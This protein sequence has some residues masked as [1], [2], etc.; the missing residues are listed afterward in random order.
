MKKLLAMLLAALLILSLAACTEKA[1][2][3]T[4]ISESNAP[5][6]AA[7]APEATA[8]V[9]PAASDPAISGSITFTH[10]R[11]DLEPEI[12]AIIDD[13]MKE[14]PDVTVDIE[15]V[16]DYVNNIGVRLS[17]NEVPD[18]FFVDE[19]II[20]HDDWGKYL[21][22][23]DGSEVA[24]RDLLGNCWLRDGHTYAISSGCSYLTFFY[25]KTLWTEAGIEGTP[26][27]WAEFESAMDKLSKLDGII[28]L[29]TQYKTGWAISEWLDVYA[30]AYQ[31]ATGGVP[32][33]LMNNW[34]NK[35]DPFSDK[36]SIQILDNFKGLIEKGYC[37]P[38]LMSSDWDMQAADFAAGTIGVY[39]A[40]EY[41]VPTMTALGMD[42]SEIGAFAMP[43]PDPNGGETDRVMLSKSYG[44]CVGKDTEYPEAATALA[45]YLA[46]NYA[47]KTNGVP[48]ID[49]VPCSVS[50][51]NDLLASKPNLYT[52]N[53]VSDEFQKIN[54]LAGIDTGTFVQEY[55]ITDDTQALIDEYNAVWANALTEYRK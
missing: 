51:I 10:Y 48:A 6:A 40:G 3:Q 45:E 5:E 44:F 4:P 30:G 26:S 17:A 53:G 25:N 21:L 42:E 31:D 35:E 27:T 54:A 37:D 15:V 7:A 55:L 22:P 19:K 46:L 13:F 49:G 41:V 52:Y 24:K 34:V 18:V 12:E 14:Y 39:L 28:P 33:T 20:R 29:T 23:L 1:P 2:A 16:S 50:A 11:T 8:P 43:N 9:S 32:D 36:V 47:V 38:D